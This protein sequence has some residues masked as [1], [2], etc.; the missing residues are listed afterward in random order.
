MW[1][2]RRFGVGLYFQTLLGVLGS[3]RRFFTDLPQE[4]G[5]GLPLG[6]L[7]LS[8]VFH[9]G[10]SLTYGPERPL[11]AAGVLFLNA[12]FMPLIAACLGHL[13]LVMI[14]GKPPGFGGVFQ[15]YA[16]SAGAT[17]LLS[18][19]PFSLWFTEPWKWVLTGIGLV[20]TCKLSLRQAL[21]VVLLSVAFLTLLFWFLAPLALQVRRSFTG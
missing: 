17:L 7:I 21:T 14:R 9:A 20:R 2:S 3:P 12:V 18:W 1:D 5:P 6:F 8:A 11:L 16:Y 13:I 4:T 15:V 10:A 19:V